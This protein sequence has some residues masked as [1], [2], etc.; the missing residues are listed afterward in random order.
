MKIEG[1]L[2]AA[3]VLAL[4]VGGRAVQAEGWSILHPF[5][6]S[7]PEAKSPEV[8][9]PARKPVKK[10]PSTLDKMGTGTKNF[11][12]G[13]GDK[14][15]MKKTTPAKPTGSYTTS[16]S[17]TTLGTPSSKIKSSSSGSS[18]NPFYKEEPKPKTLSDFVGMK[19]PE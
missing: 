10:E 11:F 1:I 9:K 12:S 13:V 8:A 18:W 15:S 19:R 5:S 17:H 7:K 2:P 4:L 3:L 14:L 6:S 16:S